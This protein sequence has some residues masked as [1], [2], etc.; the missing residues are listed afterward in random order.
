MPKFGV[1]QPASRV[2]DARFLTGHGRY[3]GELELPGQLHGAVLR[4]P[5]AHAAIRSMDTSAAE[6]A[7]GVVTV[8][9]GE[10]LARDGIGHLPC[11]MAVTSRDGS[12]AVIP[13]RPA[14][15]RERVRHV[16]D[17]VAMVV[18]ET[19]VQAGNAL[20]LIEVDYD[21]L[22]AVTDTAGALE[23]GAPQIWEQAP[24][25]L[26]FDWELGDAAATDAAF[27]RAARVVELDLIN[28]RV[29][30]NPMETRGAIGSVEPDTGR[31]VL[32]V[33]SQGSH[34]LRGILAEK[35]FGVPED[36]MRV[37]T[38]D[39]GGGFGVKIFAYPEYVMVLYAARRLG[40]PVKWIAERAETFLGDCHGRDHVSHA[41]M[42][43]DEEGRFLGMR[44]R[45]VA[46]MG[47]YLSD[48][49][50]FIA[51]EAGTGMLGGCYTTPA[52]HA[53]VRGVFTNTNPTDAYRGAG[54][55]EAAYLL[56]RLVDKCGRETGLGPV[57][58]RRRNLIRSDQMPF[59]TAL[60]KTYDTGDFVRNM[61]DALELAEWDGFED[62]RREARGRNRL[63]GIGLSTYIE[64]CAGNFAEAARVQVGGDGRV[65][66]LVG[67][68]S[69]GQGHETAYT[70]IVCEQLGLD[71]AQVTIVQGDTDRIASGWGTLG[72]RSIPVGGTAI[73]NA[74]G[75]VVAKAREKA[76]EMLEAAT[77][78][79][80]LTDGTFRIVGTDRQMTFVEVAR[81]ADPGDGRPSFDEN[82]EWEPP[83]PTFPNGTHICELEVDRDTGAVEL[84]RYTVVDDF[85]VALN[86]KLLAGQV[87][88]GV[89]QGA[90]QALLEHCV[91]EADSGQ[92]LSGSF[93]DYAMPRADLVPP[94]AFKLN[95]VPCTTNPMG[96]KGAGEAG[97]IGAPPA[98]INALVDAL[99]ELG[100]T[101]VEMPA[102]PHSLWRLMHR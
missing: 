27:Q 55:P 2:E 51:T 63:R 95:R 34:L 25:N 56:E 1:G 78:D 4:S 66:V 11:V 82:A 84:L 10:D 96:V 83:V 28:N 77:A 39:V 81:A 80:E 45:T 9:T 79:I 13:P 98:I 97:A 26:C 16:G 70:Q 76:A 37:V 6:R 42:A 47:A 72:S 52:I 71:P 65:T 57:E 58:I 87:H 62:R 12:E 75:Q 53:S 73:R 18:A 102:T 41:E 23:D 93:M 40:R 44:V 38:Q 69:N 7:P 94:I 35:V 14:L 54:R 100:V 89:A 59:A 91:Y 20:E 43:L 90:G 22:D 64:A 31:M 24:G 101:H 67:T 30:A 68:Q 88:G 49:G 36:R 60:G 46:N 33:S 85:G 29:V 5:H 99:S 15:A 92:L 48:S 17:P 8:I 32:H 74:A 3:I 21:M 61:D 19:A 50:P 86:P